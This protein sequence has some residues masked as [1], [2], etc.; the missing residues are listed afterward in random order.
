MRLIIL[1]LILVVGCSSTSGPP[2]PHWVRD[3]PTVE[4]QKP[5]AEA[6]SGVTH[7]LFFGAYKPVPGLEI[8]RLEWMPAGDQYFYPVGYDMYEHRDSTRTLEFWTWGTVP[9]DMM[10][11][12]RSHPWPPTMDPPRP[13]PDPSK[14]RP[15]RDANN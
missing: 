3:E 4:W 2:P 14:M 10:M 1:S 6:D 8:F 9:G 5:L 11:L 13:T 15:V 12:W 7:W